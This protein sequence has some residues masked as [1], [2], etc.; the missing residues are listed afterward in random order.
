M[1]ILLCRIEVYVILDHI[2]HVISFIHPVIT[3]Q[4]CRRCHCHAVA[5]CY[6]M[7]N[8]NISCSESSGIY[9]HV[10]KQM[11]TNVSEVHAASIIR[12]LMMEAARTSE[13]SVNICL[14]TW[15]YIPEDSEFHTRCRENLKSHKYN[16]R[17]RLL[18][19]TIV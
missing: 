13:T 9:C 8:T 10:V 5:Q 6:T 19:I 11:S 14:T 4:W 7:H 16:I 15:Q 18:H 3:L 1:S 12:A 17:L 2:F